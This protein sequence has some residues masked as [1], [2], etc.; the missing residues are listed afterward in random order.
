MEISLNDIPS[1]LI[2]NQNI[3]HLCT[4]KACKISSPMICSHPKCAENHGHP[5]NHLI[6]IDI[7]NKLINEKT[8]E[9]KELIMR[10]KKYFE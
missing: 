5:T 3:T 2:H 4:S 7:F 10:V 6:S 8:H 1:C 9:V